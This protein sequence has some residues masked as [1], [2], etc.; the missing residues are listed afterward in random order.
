MIVPEVQVPGHHVRVGCDVVSLDEIEHSVSTFGARFLAKIYTDDEL[1]ACAGPSRLSRLAARFA[2][3][4]A[5]IKAFS[6]PDAAFVPREIEVVT[7]KPLVTLRLSGSAAEL[8]D[9]QQW[10]QISLSLTH[11]E[12]HAAAVVVAVCATTSLDLP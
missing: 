2:A 1:A 9:E 10:R 3:K 4:E 5:A 11:A 7:A 6:R 8:A 12:C